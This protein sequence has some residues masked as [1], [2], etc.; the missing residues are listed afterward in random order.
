VRL[1][2]RLLTAGVELYEYQAAML[3]QKTMVVDGAWAT[4]GT[5]NLDN[6]SFSFNEEANV[7]FHDP[8]LVAELEQ[9]F[10]DDLAHCHQ[11]GWHEWRRR[12]AWQRLG[13]FTASILE[14][15]V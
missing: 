6:R 3:H 10:L 9:V 1:Y 13:E 14:D 7:C 8:G 4:V 12:G 11:I 15:Q 5:T 2:G